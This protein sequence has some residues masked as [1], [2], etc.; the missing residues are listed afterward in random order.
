[1]RDSFLRTALLCQNG[2]EKATNEKKHNPWPVLRVDFMSLK[3]RNNGDRLC[4]GYLPGGKSDLEISACIIP[5][6]EAFVKA[7][8]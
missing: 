2:L 8:K 4:M 6:L 3:F 5:H 7:K 1:M